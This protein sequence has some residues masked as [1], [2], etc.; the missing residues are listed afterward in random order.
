MQAY[1]VCLLGCNPA[2]TF[3][4]VNFIDYNRLD[5]HRISP[6][7]RGWGWIVFFL[8]FGYVLVSPPFFWLESFPKEEEKS[9][10]TNLQ[11]LQ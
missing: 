8:C 4:G 2:H 6:L 9:T 1:K 10:P 7:P 3:L 11:D 5:M